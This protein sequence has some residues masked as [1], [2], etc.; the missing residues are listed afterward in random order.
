MRVSLNASPLGRAESDA[1][2]AVLDSGF[3]T[4]GGR[5]A[6]EEAFAARIDRRHAVMVNSGSSANLIAVF[7]L[8][9]PFSPQRQDR[10]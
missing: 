3:L 4:M 10:A 9:N 1:A 2:K 5:C 7:A 6:A 8:A